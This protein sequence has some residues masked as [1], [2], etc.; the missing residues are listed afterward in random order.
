MDD[1][2][3]DVITLKEWFA[4]SHIDKEKRELFL[5]L[6]LAMRYVHDRGCCIKTFNPSEIEILNNSINQVKFNT[7]LKM[8]EDDLNYQNQLKNEDIFNSSILQVLLYSKFPLNTPADFIKEHY[9]D[10]ITFLPES[11]I[12]YYRG[13]IQNNVSVYFTEFELERIK[14]ENQKLENELDSNGSNN[15]FFKP[16]YKLKEKFSN[17]K[18]N[19]AIYKKVNTYKE[20]A[21]INILLYPTVVIVLVLVYSFICFLIRNLGL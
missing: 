11:D 16:I 19:N 1:K 8:P 3:I 5:Y 12:N 6:D 4:D 13:V 18:I 7:L 9:D 10:F 14:R 20:A 2:K 17:D 21:F 15:S